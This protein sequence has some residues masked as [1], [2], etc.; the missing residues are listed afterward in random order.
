[1][2]LALFQMS[3]L[4]NDAMRPDRI[5][6]AMQEAAQNGATLLVAPELALSGYGRGAAFADIAQ[7]ARGDWAERLTATARRLGISLIVGFPETRGD[8]RHISALIVDAQGTAP[9]SIY[10]KACLYGDYEKQYFHSPGPSTL[11]VDLAG[12]RVGV[13]ICYD[14][15]FPENARRLAHAGAQLIA[16]PTALPRGA[17]GAFISTH[18]IRTRAFENQVFVAYANHADSDDT[19][20]YQGC[21]SIAAPDGA[22]LTAAPETGD[23]LLY[24]EITPHDY[25]DSRAENPYL[26]DAEE[27][28][29]RM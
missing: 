25:A 28:G 7:T 12:L 13:L 29:L 26:S 8:T 14:I 9:A 23:A 27:I 3:A 1:M 2:K 18:V 19:F 5:E 4:G 24:A 16:V 6:A 15:E 20:T 22:L 21:S 10:R 11:I 17:S